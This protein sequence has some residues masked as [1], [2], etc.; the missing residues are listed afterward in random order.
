MK[1]STKKIAIA[2]S[3]F[4]C[5]QPVLFAVDSDLNKDIVALELELTKMKTRAGEYADMSEEALN[6]KIDRTKKTLE[7]K[8]EQA[9]LEAKKKED[10][11]EELKRQLLQ[12]NAELE[13]KQS[14]KPDEISE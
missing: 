3:F 4:M 9:R 10:E 7:K 5:L 14:L 6:R 2:L 11:I 8:R 12:A 1:K 13:K